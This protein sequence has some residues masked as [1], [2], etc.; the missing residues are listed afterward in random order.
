MDSDKIF[1]WG[2]NALCSGFLVVN[3]Q[4]LDELWAKVP[5]INLK[6]IG[7]K[8]RSAPGDQLILRAV[9]KTYPE[10]VGVLPRKWDITSGNGYHGS[11]RKSFNKASEEKVLDELKSAGML[12]MNG[13]GKSDKAYFMHHP[14]LTE[15]THEH[16]F[17]LLQYYARMPWSWARF[18][19]ESNKRENVSY[20]P[21][22]FTESS[23]AETAT[24][25]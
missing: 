3:V 16:S 12:H 11:Y 1:Q 19:V 7:K 10:L 24:S 6:K 22:V 25:S 18:I 14:L 17:G 5:T 23:T 8:M 21:L 13:G 4:R 2:R 15:Q 9:N 20:S